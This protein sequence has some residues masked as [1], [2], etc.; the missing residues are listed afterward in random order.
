MSDTY[1]FS[2]ILG[3][4]ITQYVA[5]KKALGRRFD[6]ERRILIH[7]DAFLCVANEDLATESF[8]AWCLTLTHLASG[9]R[10]SWMRV[11]RNLCLYRRRTEPSCFVPDLS[12][13]PPLHQPVQPYIF[14]ETE[15]ARLLEAADHLMPGSTSPLRPENFRLAVVLLYT[16]GLRRGELLRLTIG[17]F[18]PV[19]GTLLI[20]ESKFHKSR[21]LP[22]SRD[23]WREIEAYLGTRHKRHFPDS[24]DT[25]LLW[26]NHGRRGGYTGTGFGHTIRCLF[27]ATDIKTAVG[28]LPRVH[29]FRHS[30]A[31]RSLL[32]WYNASEDV[33][34][35]LPLLAIYMGHVSIVSTQ[36]YLRFISEL[37]ACA[38]E[39]FAQY[40]GSL[41]TAPDTKDGGA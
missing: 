20:R 29:D 32:R 9:V 1:P 39:R 26:N 37:T 18:D 24:A 21:L 8:D 6:I 19:E 40:C 14:T 5:L 17:D 30:F 12:Q 41:I 13:F 36:Y 10:R 34:A 23:G 7:L 11:V 16:M 33:Q 28:R 2:S 4:T 15:I 31:V 35:R 3:P 38:S 25:P 27:R 22:L